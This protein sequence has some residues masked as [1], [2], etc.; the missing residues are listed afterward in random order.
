[1]SRSR[2]LQ[3]RSPSAPRP[4]CLNTPYA[5]PPIRM[6]SS[7]ISALLFDWHDPLPCHAGRCAF[8]AVEVSIVAVVGVGE[9]DWVVGNANVPSRLLAR[10]GITSYHRARDLWDADA[11]LLNHPSSAIPY[12][13]DAIGCE[14]GHCD[15]LIVTIVLIFILLI[16]VVAIVFFFVSSRI[17][18][19][20]FFFF[21]TS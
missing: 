16:L 14:K 12:S 2:R 5:C 20:L 15:G 6:S 10:N 1:M 18:I 17:V 11:E 3:T 7:S 19:L 13:S 9:D 8:F 4:S 21:V